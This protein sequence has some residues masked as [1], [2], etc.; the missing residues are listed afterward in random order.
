MYLAWFNNVNVSTATEQITKDYVDVIG[1]DSGWLSGEY[2]YKT[3]APRATP[4]AS[5]N[6][7]NLELENLLRCGIISPVR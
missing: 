7:V 1:Q 3:V 2:E 5:R 6:Q 4:V